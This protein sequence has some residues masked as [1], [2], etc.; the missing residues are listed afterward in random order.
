M[1][2]KRLLL[3]L[4]VALFLPIATMA[5]AQTITFNLENESD[6]DIQIEFYSQDRNHAWPGGD[7]AYNLASGKENSYRLQCRDGEKICY[8]AWVKGKSSTYWGVGLRN[9]QSCESCC[10]NCGEGN[11]SKR[12]TNPE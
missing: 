8:G 1:G 12:L 2:F 7:Q 10:Q 11:L 9:Q 3:A 5:S 4:G 6:Y